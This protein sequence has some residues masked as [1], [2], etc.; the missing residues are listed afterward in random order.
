MYVRLKIHRTVVCK[1]RPRFG[2]AKET[3]RLE[4]LGLSGIA[5]ISIHRSSKAV[6][7]IIMKIQ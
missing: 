5:V 4:S 6:L 2:E 1:N 3:R 7:S